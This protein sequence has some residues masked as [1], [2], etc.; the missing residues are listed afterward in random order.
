M[1]DFNFFSEIE[2]IRK[3]SGSWKHERLELE[4][5]Y[6]IED[7]P[8]RSPLFFMCL[9]FTNS[10]S[11]AIRDFFA[12]KTLEAIGDVCPKRENGDK[13]DNI[14]PSSNVTKQFE[15]SLISLTI[16]LFVLDYPMLWERIEDILNAVL[17]N[18]EKRKGSFIDGEHLDYY[19]SVINTCFK[20]NEDAFGTVRTFWEDLVV[21]AIRYKNK[22]IKKKIFSFTE[23]Y[24]QV[25]LE[26]A[27]NKLERYWSLS[28]YVYSIDEVFTFASDLFSHKSLRKLIELNKK[29]LDT[30]QAKSLDEIR[31]FWITSL[32]GLFTLDRAFK[33]YIKL[34]P[35]LKAEKESR[36][37]GQLDFQDPVIQPAQMKAIIPPSDPVHKRINLNKEEE[38][39]PVKSFLPH[40]TISPRFKV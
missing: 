2:E 25:F 10:G 12:F 11:L 21:S 38:N 3:Q 4:L 34:T 28:H 22:Q 15:D 24:L 16:M 8:W 19:E 40:L 6:F 30:I 18:I 20:K 36:E 37:S 27:K 9:Y 5:E 1:S 13:G 32:V 31:F 39:K 29:K 14:K 35:H 33:R 7:A 23:Q 26:E 17:K